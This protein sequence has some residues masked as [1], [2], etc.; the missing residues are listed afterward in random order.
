VF[1]HIGAFP[2]KCTI[3]HP[4]HTTVARKVSNFIKTKSLSGKEQSFGQYFINSEE[5]HAWHIIQSG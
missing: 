3:K 4:F 5:N 2:N 1:A